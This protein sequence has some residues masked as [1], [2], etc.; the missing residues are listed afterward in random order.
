MG[1]VQSQIYG[2]ISM[3]RLVVLVLLLI[4]PA[5]YVCSITITDLPS[6]LQACIGSNNCVVDTRA[7]VVTIGQ[8]E[9]YYFA[10]NLQGTP[11]F[12]YALRYSLLYPSA[13]IS[14]PGTITYTGDIWLTLYNSYDLSLD[15]NPVT[16]YT[17]KVSPQPGN[18]FLGDSTGLDIDVTMTSAALLSGA[19]FE[20]VGLDDNNMDIYQAN[21]TLQSDMGGNALVP[22]LA[23]GCLSTA[24]LNL[25]YLDYVQS[26]NTATLQFN[27]GDSRKLL[28]GLTSK[29]D[30][31]PEEGG[32]FVSQ[33]YYVASVPLPAT[34]WLFGAGFA[35]LLGIARKKKA[36]RRV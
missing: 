5:E 8:M 16:I 12:G 3:P 25:I 33:S 17:D 15:A 34:M 18:L 23:E 1:K 27:P 28:Y 32:Y 6:Q 14:G 2:G 21:M 10:D 30:A 4:S 20:M 31:A 35:G 24:D 22:C 36:C 9:A 19:G 13:E 7:P 29:Y 11:A 26:G